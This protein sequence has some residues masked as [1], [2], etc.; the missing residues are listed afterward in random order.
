MSAAIREEIF[1][2]AIVADLD[3][4]FQGGCVHHGC[5]PE[6]DPDVVL[7][8]GS[9]EEDEVGLATSSP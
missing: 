2:D 9:A 8:T 3:G 4:F 1:V 5:V 6:G 7:L